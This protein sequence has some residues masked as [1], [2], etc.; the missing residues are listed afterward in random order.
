[1]LVTQRTIGANVRLALSS[2]SSKYIPFRLG[3][4][5]NDFNRIQPDVSAQI[6]A[7]S[8]T[9]ARIPTRRIIS[10]V[11]RGFFQKVSIWLKSSITSRSFDLKTNRTGT[12]VT[13]CTGITA[14]Q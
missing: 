2:R 14:A 1:M 3:A 9:I 6:G 11:G 8:A 10:I 4:Q 5:W 13:I 7:A 12:S